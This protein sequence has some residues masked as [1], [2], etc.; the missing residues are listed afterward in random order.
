MS[1]SNP[2]NI[3][4]YR[5]EYAWPT[6][7]MWRASM[8]QA[9]GVKDP[10]TWEGQVNYLNHLATTYTIYLAINNATQEETGSEV[11][12]VVGFIVFGDTELD[13]LY[14]HVDYQG[15]GIGPRLLA[16]AKEQSPGKLQLYTFAVNE[17]A[18]R[19][20]ERHGFYIIGR[21]IERESGMADIR[22]EWV[23]K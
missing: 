15:M 11:G 22:Y 4:E 6:V 14:I 23:A 10:H 16:L 2:I 17:N 8:E 1:K 19:F 12:Q 7:R 5:E 20:Y 9:L 18:Q 21:G 13:Q 3:I